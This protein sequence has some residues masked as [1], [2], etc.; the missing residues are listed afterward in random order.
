MK[1]YFVRSGDGYYPGRLQN[2]LI[3]PSK[4]FYLSR[5]GTL[6]RQQKAIDPRLPGAKTLLMRLVLL[7]VD[8]GTLYGEM[9]RLD[10]QDVWGF[11]ERAWS[12]KRDHPMRG[13]PEQLNIPKAL[14]A[15]P[16][17]REEIIE[18]SD[19]YEIS[20]DYLPP[21]FAAGIHAVKNF[22]NALGQLCHTHDDIGLG[23]LQ[24]TS[25]LISGL[26]SLGDARMWNKDWY[27]VD[28]PDE[29]FNAMI[30]KQYEPKGAWRMG[31]YARVLQG[32]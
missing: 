23:V 6:K 1:R 18:L 19:A 12:V 9:H 22:E 17:T 11:L 24:S 29:A 10:D 32:R 15:D 28:G 14:W 3:S 4:R 27:A 7:D 8:T 30:D 13:I 5:S 31:P 26:A 25:A 2:L 20:I 21:G 16:S